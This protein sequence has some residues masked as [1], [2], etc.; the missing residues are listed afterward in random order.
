MRVKVSNRSTPY[1]FHS[2]HGQVLFR[3]EE[4]EVSHERFDGRMSPPSVRVNFSRGD[5]VAVL[6]YAG[7]TDEIVLVEQFR[8]PVYASLPESE[9]AGRGWIL[10]TV[11]GIKDAGGP[12]VARR[13]LL[14][15]TGYALSGAL[16]H[17]TTAY[18][19]PG[20][21][22]E[23][24]ELYLAH[25]SKLEGIRKHAG[26]EAETEDIRTHT[27]PFAE[28]LRMVADG[29]IVDSKTIIALYMLKERLEG[30]R[31]T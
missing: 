11:A 7:D 29:R 27:I 19:S 23:R 16:E 4:A 1:A 15:E 5:S 3:M 10:E 20:G 24:V 21:T 12:D 28:A 31:E 2:P 9:R 14:E 13:E 25:V 22:S 30:R 18:V 6:L 8:Y 17:L 26:L